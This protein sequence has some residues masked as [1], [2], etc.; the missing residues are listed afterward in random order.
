MKGLYHVYDNNHCFLS[1]IGH[2]MFVFNVIFDI[3]E[4]QHTK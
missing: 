1:K 3:T 4:S 2:I